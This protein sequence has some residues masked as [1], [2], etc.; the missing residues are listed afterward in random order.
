MMLNIPF[1]D[2]SEMSPSQLLCIHSQP[3]IDS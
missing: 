3:L 2:M 1:H